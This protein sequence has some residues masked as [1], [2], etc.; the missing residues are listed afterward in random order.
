MHGGDPGNFNDIAE[1]MKRQLIITSFANGPGPDPDQFSGLIVMGGRENVDQQDLYPYL[2]DEIDYIK[3]WL[4]SDKPMLGVCLGAQLL[5]LASGGKAERME[6]SEIGWHSFAH[7]ESARLDPVLA[8]VEEQVA[9]Q[10]HSYTTLPASGAQIL[11]SNDYGVQAFRYR[12]SWGVQF[13][14]EGNRQTI[15]RWSQELLSQGDRARVDNLS[16]GISLYGP[17]W[18]RY[19]SE[20]FGRFL[21]LSEGE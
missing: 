9:L 19:G 11:A 21:S 4:E 2:K 14:P 17:A 15:E 13:H 5:S 3:D 10:W 6:E 1:L 20:L 8:N 12:Q 7:H 18:R 16:Q